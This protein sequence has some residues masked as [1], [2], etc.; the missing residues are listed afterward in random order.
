[1]QSSR[2]YRCANCKCKVGESPPKRCSVCGVITF[3]LY[4]PFQFD[5]TFSIRRLFLLIL[6]VSVYLALFRPGPHT[7]IENNPMGWPFYLFDMQ[8]MSDWLIG[9]PI[10][11]SIVFCLSAC[12]TVFILFPRILTG[13]IAAIGILVWIGIGNFLAMAASA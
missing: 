13:I 12:V 8:S 9:G 6:F 5:A 1:M 11:F 4:K 3:E 10:V 2:L 7:S